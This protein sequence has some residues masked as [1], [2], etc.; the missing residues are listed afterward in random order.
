MKDNTLGERLRAAR[1]AAGL[2]QRAVARATGIRQ[3]HVSALETGRYGRGGPYGYDPTAAT[4]ARLAD[5]LGVTA[6]WLRG[7]TTTGGPAGPPEKEA[8]R[9]CR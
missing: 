3:P 7:D 2:S 8:K 5:A 4:V 6:A 9:P 1:V